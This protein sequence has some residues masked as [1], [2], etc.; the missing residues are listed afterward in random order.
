LEYR[1]QI[2]KKTAKRIYYRDK[3]EAINA[4]GEPIGPDNDPYEG[5]V[6]I[7]DRQ[8]LEADGETRNRGRHWSADDYH[9]YISLEALGNNR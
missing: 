7:V 8:K 4:S 1:F 2:I 9:L 5:K 3:G 6:G